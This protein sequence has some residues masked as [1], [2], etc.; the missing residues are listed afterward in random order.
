[1]THPSKTIDPGSVHDYY[2]S[3]IDSVDSI[4]YTVDRDLRIVGVNR[5][6]NVFALENG[7]PHLTE[8]HILGARLLDQMQG[9]P[10][11]RWQQVCHQILNGQLA[12][13]LDEVA[14]SE[15]F[16]WRHYTLT[17][18]PLKSGQGEILGITFVSTNITQLK[19]AEA[20]MFQRLV[21]VRGLRQVAQTAGAGFT[22]RAF[23]RQ[24]TADIAHLFDAGRCIIFRWHESSGHLQA[25]MPAFGLSERQLVDLTLDIGDPTDP[26]SL[27]QDL[28]EKDYI[29]LN[30]GDAAPRQIVETAVRVDRLAAM[31]AVLRVSGRVHGTILVA[32]R[33]RP[34]TEQEGQLLAAFAV[35][36]VLAIEDAELNQR[37]LNRS[38]Q[39]AAA[40]EALRHTTRLA[41][42]IRVPL[43]V[44]RGY[45]ELLCDGA[46]GAVS[47]EQAATLDILRQKT[48]DIA[49]M[50]GRLTP[51]PSPSEINRYELLLLA[52]L[53]RQVIDRRLVALEAAGL[54]LI[55]DLPAAG[56]PACMVTGQPDALFNV[57]DALLDNAIKFSPYGGVVH[58]SLH[59]SP[60]IVYVRVDDPGVGIA[61]PQLLQIWQPKKPETLSDAL[62]LV[63]VKRIV[64]EHGGQVWVDSQAGQGSTFYVALPKIIKT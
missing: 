54:D 45:L 17:A 60:E 53:V 48:R 41:E 2:Q 37:L 6:W 30:E 46:L 56:D 38:R 52:D 28:E 62:D 63:E 57:F 47:G 21:E 24:V 16:A 61:T 31:M 44:L 18:S 51:S 64:E 50:L 34:F 15:P 35:P 10:R 27:W 19:R 59:E 40:R 13:Y 14:S 36:V 39:L 4:V 26:S 7:A 58:I 9:D 22:A 49:D 3:V 32:S 43:T 11:Q 20:E 5:R 8:E 25:Q 1:M 33:D 55:A 42:S 12:R 23:Y 29:L